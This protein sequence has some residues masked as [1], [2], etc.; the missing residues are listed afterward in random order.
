MVQLPAEFSVKTRFIAANWAAAVAAFGAGNFCG[1]KAAALV[2][3]FNRTSASC[4]H[5]S[6]QLDRCSAAFVAEHPSDNCSKQNRLFDDV[7]FKTL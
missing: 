4:D 1:Q 6:L 2:S 5:C 3:V 7:D